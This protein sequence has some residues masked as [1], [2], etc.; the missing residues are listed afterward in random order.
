VNTGDT[1]DRAE[2]D[3]APSR[4][5]TCGRHEPWRRYQFDQGGWTACATAL[6]ACA[7]ECQRAFRQ[8]RCKSRP[9]RLQVCAAQVL[10]ACQGTGQGFKFP[11]FPAPAVAKTTGA[12]QQVIDITLQGE[13]GKKLG[14]VFE[15][16]TEPPEVKSVKEG[17]LAAQ[18]LTVAAEITASPL[19]PLPHATRALARPA[20]SAQL[21]WAA[22]QSLVRFWC[23]RGHRRHQ[24]SSR[25]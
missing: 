24:G 3:A 10:F 16:E 11:S 20:F 19:P 15:K 6:Q 1:K 18:V 23:V 4:R 21:S 25:R 22:A 8:R 14:L 5:Y 17:G 2:D 7:S 9:K 12:G 13:E